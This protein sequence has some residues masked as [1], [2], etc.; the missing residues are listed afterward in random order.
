MELNSVFALFIYIRLFG[1]RIHTATAVHGCSADGHSW[2]HARQRSVV[3]QRKKDVHSHKLDGEV[4]W[5]WIARLTPERSWKIYWKPVLL[6]RHPEDYKCQCPEP[7]NDQGPKKINNRELIHK[8]FWVNKTTWVLSRWQKHQPCVEG[9]RNG[10]GICT[11]EPEPSF[12]KLKSQTR[13]TCIA[14]QTTN[15]PVFTEMFVQ[16][17]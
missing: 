16:S 15:F 9:F 14:L 10:N 13:K 5:P 1:I 7:P 6:G 17:F 3:S 4:D 2:H 8:Q 11:T 12:S